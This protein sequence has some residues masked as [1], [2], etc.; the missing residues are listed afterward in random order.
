MRKPSPGSFPFKGLG[1]STD[2]AYQVAKTAGQVHS[3]ICECLT[4]ENACAI[5]LA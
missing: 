2:F 4:L 5:R 1:R 3:D